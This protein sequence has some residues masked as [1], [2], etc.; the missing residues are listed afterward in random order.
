HRLWHFNKQHARLHIR[1]DL[2][3]SAWGGRAK[4]LTIPANG[5]L[6]ITRSI[7]QADRAWATLI[8]DGY[9]PAQAELDLSQP[10]TTVEL[11]RQPRIE[12]TVDLNGP[13]ASK[14]ERVDIMVCA[15]PP[16]DA[17][18]A[19]TSSVN[20]EA[21]SRSMIMDYGQFDHSLKGAPAGGVSV[22]PWPMAQ[23]T[24]V[25]IRPTARTGY[26]PMNISAFGPFQRDEGSVTCNLEIPGW[27]VTGSIEGEGEG[28]GLAD[29]RGSHIFARV[30]SATTGDPIQD[31]E[32][33]RMIAGKHRGVAESEADGTLQASIN[34][35]EEGCRISHRLYHPV[36]LSPLKVRHGEAIELGEIALEPL[37]QV[38]GQLLDLAGNPLGE[39]RS[40]S[41][42]DPELGERWVRCEDDGSFI[43]GVSGSPPAWV[44][45]SDPD[46]PRRIKSK[47]ALV[48]SHA[49]IE[50]GADNA[51][52]CR[53]PP[54]AAV[55]VEIV[56]LDANVLSIFAPMILVGPDGA[57]AKLYHTNT[58]G[59]KALFDLS[60]PPGTYTM[61]SGW[62]IS[63]P[64]TTIEV[65]PGVHTEP[66]IVTIQGQPRVR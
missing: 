23:E 43:L 4:E 12:V 46:S 16:L 29:K 60:L 48:P 50:T 8:V 54:G 11:V 65:A 52:V 26:E 25:Y 42:Q 15:L 57:Q 58:R 41:W 44:F 24:W 47:V 51:M 18:E 62:V 22:F 61:V 6:L 39:D 36:F 30:V 7:L 2:P 55:T 1:P 10:G 14:T 20:G 32:F 19:A 63:I 27:V 34:R 49:D 5:E 31:A 37:N 3:E 33:L 45:V 56:G 13:G 40:I 38:H 35:D 28:A 59:G 53:I 9:E 21:G 66:I 17:A 64:P